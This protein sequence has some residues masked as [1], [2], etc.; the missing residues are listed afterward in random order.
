MLTPKTEA[1]SVPLNLDARERIAV[2]AFSQ[3]LQLLYMNELAQTLTCPVGPSTALLASFIPPD[4][5]RL[6]ESLQRLERE[7]V[8]P[9]RCEIWHAL[10]PWLLQGFRLP[11]DPLADTT[12]IIILMEPLTD[13][14]TRLREWA[15]LGLTPRESDIARLVVRGL[16]NKQIA[17]QLSLA[18]Q[19]V[20]D[21]M[22][23]IMVKTQTSTRTALVAY[24]LTRARQDP[25]ESLGSQKCTASTDVL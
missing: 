6:A 5:L 10:R 7:E 25:W 20:K 13:L 12:V 19:T 11:T 8:R 22:K 16:T 21:H 4:V 18:E 17:A 2:F 24:L 3:L 23:H 14:S 15:Q 1:H 9:A